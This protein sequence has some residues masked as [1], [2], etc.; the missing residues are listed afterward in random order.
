MG[1]IPE[2][3]MY[4][5]WYPDGTQPVTIAPKFVFLG[6]ESFGQDKSAPVPTAPLHSPVMLQVHAGTQG[7]SI[8]YQVERVSER[9]GPDDGGAPK[10]DRAGEQP[11]VG[12]TSSTG[13]NLYRAPVRLPEGELILRARAFRIGYAASDETE[14]RVEVVSR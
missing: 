9:A 7:S 1:E 14:V 4:R 12:A 3:V 10:R 5:M 11:N 2:D 8:E 6:S 13:W